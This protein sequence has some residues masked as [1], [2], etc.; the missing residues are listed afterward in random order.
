MLWCADGCAVWI[1]TIVVA[2]DSMVIRKIVSH[3]LSANNC[4]HHVCSDGDEAWKWIQQHSSICAALI[5]DLEMPKMGGDTLVTLMRESYPNIPCFIV[6]GKDMSLDIPEGA[7]RAI[8]K[9]ITSE[10]VLSLLDEVA[11]LQ[12]C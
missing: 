1:G 8:V 7:R 4:T 5:T 11:S 6:S 10:Q 3:Y 9:P 12:S 2:D